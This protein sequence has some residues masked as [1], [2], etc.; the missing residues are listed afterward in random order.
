MPVSMDWFEIWSNDS[1][2]SDFYKELFGF[3]IQPMEG[4]D[5]YNLIMVDEK[6]IGGIGLNEAASG[7]P[8]HITPYFTVSDLKEYLEK[9]VQ[10]GSEVI[11]DISSIPGD[12]EFAIFKAPDGNYIGICKM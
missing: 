5:N 2:S 1:K 4:V 10:L 12:G 6:G 9:A 3:T 8:P 7:Q 11:V